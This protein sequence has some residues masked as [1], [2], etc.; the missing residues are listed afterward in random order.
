MGYRVFFSCLIFFSAMTL[1][2]KE[3]NPAFEDP[4]SVRL[5][6][7]RYLAK[8]LREEFVGFAAEDIS[9]SVSKLDPRLRLP[10][11][12]EPLRNEIASPR[13]YTSNISIK[14]ICSGSKLWSV[15]VPA[16]VEVFAHV[17]VLSRSL[18]RGTVL[19]SED[20]MLVRMSLTQAGFG[21]VRD[22]NQVIGMELK[23]RLQAGDPVRLSHVKAPVV[24]KK[25]DRVVLEAGNSHIT[26]VTS[27]KALGQGQVGDQIQ[28]RNE[29][30][31][32]VVEAEIVAPGRVK[33]LL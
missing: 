30:S 17:A 14:V 33:I 3:I 1:Q 32:K 9:I 26:V 8:S 5:Q 10:K 18:D 19:S 31:S 13:P 24:V 22:M 20:V 7:E 16:K 28:V 27:A 12:T 21:H 2:A 23:R 11:C 29:K 25:G 4:E 15:F 6:V